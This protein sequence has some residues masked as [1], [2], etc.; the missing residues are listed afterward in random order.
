MRTI[1][2]LLAVAGFSTGLIVAC[3]GGL[4]SPSDSLLG[5]DPIPNS[6]DPVG[7]STD[8]S[9]SST[10]PTGTGGCVCPVG[11]W[12]CGGAIDST[13]QVS[14]QNGVCTIDQV[15]TIDCTGHFTAKGQSGSVK[16][17]G[18]DLYAC[19]G[20]TC[21]TCKPKTT[22]IDPDASALPD[23]GVK[24]TGI[25][26]MGVKDVAKDSPAKVC[27][28]SCNVNSDCQSTCPVAPNGFV[29]CCDPNAFVCYQDT[30][31]P[32]P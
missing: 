3:G 32:G 23:V 8:P 7:S 19:V 25:P 24:D 22:T 20:S 27:A 31:C 28:S 11:T 1:S 17:Q 5:N 16:V 18:S 4:G 30:T 26:D 10:D 14:L 12:S 29:N 21:A 6:G 13:V 2:S 15:V 9:G